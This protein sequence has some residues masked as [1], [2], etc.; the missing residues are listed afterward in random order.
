MLD[1]LL[2]FYNILFYM[3]FFYYKL[4]AEQNMQQIQAKNR[5]LGRINRDLHSNNQILKNENI[6][7]KDNLLKEYNLWNSRQDL[8]ILVTKNRVLLLHR[9]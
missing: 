5:E 6:K 2:R 4:L 9:F 1:F 7:L 8:N 3:N